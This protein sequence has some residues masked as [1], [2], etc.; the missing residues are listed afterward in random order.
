MIL[1]GMNIALW[2]ILIEYIGKNSKNILLKKV[3][4]NKNENIS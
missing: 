4:A 1:V 3:S 2:S